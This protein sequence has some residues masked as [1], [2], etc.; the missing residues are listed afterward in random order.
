MTKST[1]QPGSF[2]SRW[3]KAIK[4]MPSTYEHPAASAPSQPAAKPKLT[5]AQT[6]VMK[7]LGHGWIAYPAGGSAVT[8]NGQRLCNVDTLMA[9]SRLGL[10]TQDDDRCWAATEAGA[11]L[12]KERGL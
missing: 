6:R 11:A 10:V 5:E 7:W 9:L 12:T 4:D 1:T 2:V 8:V 3:S